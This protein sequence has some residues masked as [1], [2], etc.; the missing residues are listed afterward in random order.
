MPIKFSRPALLTSF[1]HGDGFGLLRD[2]ITEGLPALK[3]GVG[4][5]DLSVGGLGK[6]N[7]EPAS[8]QKHEATTGLWYAV[9]RHL[10]D[11]PAWMISGGSQLTHEL[12][13]YSRAALL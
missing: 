9:V 3:L 1:A 4:Y 7:R 10:H 8:R 12:A 5:R 2:H 11:L 6:W 13:E